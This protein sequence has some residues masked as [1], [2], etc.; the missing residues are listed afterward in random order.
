MTTKQKNPLTFKPKATSSARTGKD[1]KHVAPKKIGK[2]RKAFNV[3]WFILNM[4]GALALIICS[5]GGTLDPMKHPLG[6]LPAMAFPGA[7]AGIV[8][9]FVLD[10]IWWRRT[11]MVAGVAMLLCIVPISNFTPLNLPRRALSPE[12]KELSFTLMTYNTMAFSVQRGVSYE[13][14][15]QISY[16]LAE[17][18]DVV[19]VQELMAMMKNQDTKITQAQIDS[20]HHRPYFLTNSYLQA[21]FSKYPVEHIPLDFV[22]AEG[23][24]DIAGWRL[25]IHDEVVNVFSL[26]LRSLF[27]THHDKEAFSK[28]VRADD[29]NRSSLRTLKTGILEKIVDASRL[30]SLQ[31]DSLKGYVKKYGGPNTIVCG[32][33]NEPVGCWGLH[34]L[35]EDCKMKQVY[36]RVGFGPMITYN[37]NKFWVRI[38]HVLYRGDLEPYSMKRGNLRASDHY[39]LTTTFIK[40]TLTEP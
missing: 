26:H 36:P 20:L 31:I 13:I 19:C 12:Q 14:N 1:A 4:L 29:I 2:W 39:P 9:L 38:D 32:D 25:K 3:V 23:K 5:V 28:I 10:L 22:N 18:P 15:P 21:I 40:K 27:F 17:D 37:A 8:V 33:F 6:V 16:I 35:G 30:R 11:A 34:T 7:L 24:G